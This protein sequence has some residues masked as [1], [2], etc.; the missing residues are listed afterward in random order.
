MVTVAPDAAPRLK[1]MLAEPGSRG[2]A[3][4]VSILGFA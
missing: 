4:R 2:R 3:F 1:A